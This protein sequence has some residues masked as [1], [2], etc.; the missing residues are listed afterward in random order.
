MPASLNATSRWSPRG[1]SATA[2]C[3]NA[4]S[5]PNSTA[6][7]QSAMREL[8]TA[9]APRNAQVITDHRA[10]AGLPADRPR[11]DDQGAQAL[12]GAVD[13]AQRGRP[14]Q[15][16]QLAEGDAGV[17][18]VHRHQQH[19]AGVPVQQ[20]RPLQEL[21]ALHARQVLL[22]GHRDAEAFLR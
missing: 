21:H 15:R 20:V 18:A 9:D 12:G 14:L 8:A 1:R 4:N 11:L 5:A 10:A 19:P 7:S 16:R 22:A 6:C 17:V 2:R 13:A 3:V